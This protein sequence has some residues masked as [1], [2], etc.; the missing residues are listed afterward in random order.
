MYLKHFGLEQYPFTLT[1]DTEFFLYYS[2]FKD[3]FDVLEYA[4]SSGEGFTKITG[5]VGTGKT[6]LCRKLLN[7]LDDHFLPVHI[8][9]SF[10]NPEALHIALAKKIG[11]RK[12]SIHGESRLLELINE[13][14]MSLHAEGK[15]VVLLMDEAQTLPDDT[16]EALRRYSNFETEKNKLLQL[17]IFGQPELDTRLQ[18]DHFRQLRQ[19]IIFNHK[20][21]PLASDALSVYVQHRLHVAGYR[22]VPLFCPHALK[23]LQKGSCGVPR[24]INVL[25]HKAMLVAFGRGDTVIDPVSVRNAIADSDS[26]NSKRMRQPVTAALCSLLGLASASVST[27]R[28]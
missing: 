3:G 23:L 13:Q 8:P 27:T 17:V 1:P 22:G 6:L 14:L 21:K 18:Q 12:G 15:Q 10:I 20:L 19:R 4:L 9:N 2:E 25:A 11:V 7:S 26:V 16:M 28:H 24:L 5:E